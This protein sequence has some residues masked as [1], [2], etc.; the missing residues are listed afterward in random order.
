MLTV[1]ESGRRRCS[2]EPRGNSLRAAQPA[3][4]AGGA[5]PFSLSV[6]ARAL[7]LQA[8]TLHALREPFGRL[9]EMT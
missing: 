6:G 1:T 4:P 3:G 9:H 8:H 7:Q 2:W 5:A